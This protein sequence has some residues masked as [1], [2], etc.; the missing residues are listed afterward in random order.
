MM[1]RIQTYW[2]TWAKA[3]TTTRDSLLQP[4]TAK[5]EKKKKK[6]RHKTKHG[7]KKHGHIL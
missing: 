6:E 2:T 5:K 3:G 4:L 7:E 1:D